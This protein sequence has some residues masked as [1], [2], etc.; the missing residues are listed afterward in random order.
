M[1]EIGVYNLVWGILKE[2]NIIST[3][4]DFSYKRNDVIM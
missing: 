4:W 1:K 3:K 2:K